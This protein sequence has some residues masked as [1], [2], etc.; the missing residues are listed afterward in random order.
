[1]ADDKNV[2]V[3][4]N[5]TPNLTDNSGGSHKLTLTSAFS[6]LPTL[7]NNGDY[8]SDSNKC[9]SSDDED[10]NILIYAK[11]TSSTDQDS[12]INLKNVSDHVSDHVSNHVIDQSTYL[13]TKHYT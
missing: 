2:I 9:G 1:M 12:N 11:N 4:I 3:E 7:T 5:D 13:V 10:K 6:A 8:F